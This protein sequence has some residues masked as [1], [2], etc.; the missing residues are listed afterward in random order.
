MTSP[1]G[2]E[3]ILVASLDQCGLSKRQIEAIAKEGYLTLTNFLLNR[4]SDIDSIVKKFAVLREVGAIKLGHMHVL[5]LKALL[6][7]LKNQVRHG[8]DLN[9]QCE[10]FGQYELKELIR[11][12]ETYE[13]MDK[14]K[15]TKTTAPDKF[16]PHSLHGWTQFNRNLQNYLAS[17]QG[18]S[19][20]PLSYVIQK[21]EFLDVAPPGEDAMEEMIRLAPLCGT[22]YLEDKKRVYQIIR[23][24]VSRT[25]SWIWMQDVWNEDGR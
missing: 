21:E 18:I 20:V 7:W 24:A 19:R 11:A 4:Y 13:D 10:D 12:L 8:I 14:F 9:D 2:M 5:H 3:F 1:N 22:A 15:D 23:D 6:Y 25:D 17:I 16:Q